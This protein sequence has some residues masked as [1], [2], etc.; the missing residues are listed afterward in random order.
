VNHHA[1]NH[2]QGKAALLLGLRAG[3]P[4]SETKNWGAHQSSLYLRANQEKIKTENQNL[5]LLFPNEATSAAR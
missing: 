1:G 4:A 3:I 2:E 5:A